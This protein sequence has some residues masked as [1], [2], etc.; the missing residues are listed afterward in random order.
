MSEH[1]SGAPLPKI[2][3]KILHGSSQGRIHVDSR[4]CTRTAKNKVNCKCQI[5][6]LFAPPPPNQFLCTHSL[7]AQH[8]QM[9]QYAAHSPTCFTHEYGTGRS[10]GESWHPA[11]PAPILTHFASHPAARTSPSPSPSH[12]TSSILNSTTLI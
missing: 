4:G 7:T 5:L 3:E 2:D 11:S 6:T 9:A 10:P 1:E 8:T 12:V